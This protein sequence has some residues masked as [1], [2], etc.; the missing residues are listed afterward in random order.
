M[1]GSRYAARSP[2]LDQLIANHIA[3]ED[4]LPSI[5][6]SVYNNPRNVNHAGRDLNAID[7][8]DWSKPLAPFYPHRKR[9]L[10]LDGLSLA[11]AELDV[12]GDRHPKGWLQ[13]WTGNWAYMDGSRY[14]ARS[15]SLDQLI[16]AQPDP[17]T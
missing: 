1:D 11:T 8:A 5:E 7:K 4:R 13:A 17:T 3:R 15:P 12:D 2:S 16:A 14:A 9:L 6:M 10:A